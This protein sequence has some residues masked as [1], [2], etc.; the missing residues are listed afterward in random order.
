MQARELRVGQE[1]TEEVRL[2]VF[3]ARELELTRGYVR[4]LLASGRVRLEGQPAPK[5][6]LL[7]SGDRISVGAFRHPSEGVAPRADLDLPELSRSAGLVAFD[8]P[9]G[10]PTQPLDFDEDRTALSAAIARIP[11]IA[12]ASPHPLEGGLVH[13]LDTATS[14]VLVFA[15]DA[16]T[17]KRA[18]RAFAERRVEKRYLARVHGR[19]HGTH[20]L[21]LRLEHRGARMRVVASGGR[22]ALTW[23]CALR[24]E[25][26]E[27]LVEVRPA[28]G[29]TH[30]IRVTLAHLGHPIVGDRSY[31]SPVALERHWLHAAEIRLLDLEA[32]SPPP[33]QLRP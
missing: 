23:L 6:A 14:G 30:Q 9:A 1:A 21:A 18:R 17:W 15:T 5:G 26:D 20:D 29:L 16:G 10:L 11:E 33:A 32:S 27:T 19:L 7:R 13:R 3:L 28:T 22:L 31:G 2:D 8:K 24:A 25:G 4:R 12:R